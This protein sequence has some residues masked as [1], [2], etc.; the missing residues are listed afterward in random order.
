MNS[1]EILDRKCTALF[2]NTGS[3]DELETIRNELNAM[4]TTTALP[5]LCAL[6]E[7][8]HQV[9]APYFCA[10]MMLLV[11]EK[12][13]KE[14]KLSEKETLN[15]WLYRI[16]L[17]DYARFPKYVV[18]IFVECMARMTKLNGKRDVIRLSWSEIAVN[19]LIRSGE[20]TKCVHG[21]Q[22]LEILI[23]EIN[24]RRPMYPECLHKTVLEHFRDHHLLTFFRLALNLLEDGIVPSVERACALSALFHVI[25]SYDFSDSGMGEQGEED[26]GPT[27][28]PLA[29]RETIFTSNVLN[30]LWTLY[31]QRPE[32]I[33][34]ESLIGF[35]TVRRSFFPTEEQRK[36]WISTNVEKLHGIMNPQQ[37]LENT[38]TLFTL[39]RMHSRL[40]SIYSLA[41]LSSVPLFEPWI[42]SYAKIT[43]DALKKWDITF[44]AW[45]TLMSFWA[46]LSNVRPL[47]A[48]S[49]V[50]SSSVLTR[51]LV[52]VCQT[53]V[54]AC[55]NLGETASPSSKTHENLLQNPERVLVLLETLSHLIR[56]HYF[57]LGGFL[58]DHFT[59]LCT[60]LRAVSSF[61]TQGVT[62]RKLT[63][64]VYIISLVVR[65]AVTR[66]AMRNGEDVID[67]NLMSCV[68]RFIYHNRTREISTAFEN[69]E[70]SM[71]HAL[72]SF[73]L[74][75]LEEDN[76]STR[77]ALRRLIV[78]LED[79]R[80]VYSDTT[81]I[82]E[83]IV[84]KIIYNLQHCSASPSIIT[85][86]LTLLSDLAK[87]S[88]LG[89]RLL[90]LQAIKQLLKAHQEG[91][92]S[93]SFLDNQTQ[94]KHRIKY[95]QALSTILFREGYTE[96]LFRILL[97]PVD[98]IFHQITDSTRA[99]SSNFVSVVTN[100]L[101]DLLGISRACSSRKTYNSFFDWIYE[102]HRQSL[103]SLVPSCSNELE[104][105][106]VFLKTISDIVRLEPQR[107]TFEP[108][109]PK[110]LLLF[111]WIAE[112]LQNMARQFITAWP[113]VQSLDQVFLLNKQCS[114][115]LIALQ[116]CFSGNF[117]NLGV[118]EVYHDDI[119]DKTI[120]AAFQ[121]L[122]C[123]LTG[124][125]FQH[126]KLCEAYFLFLGSLCGMQ[127]SL[128]CKLRTAR[129]VNF[130]QSIEAA[131]RRDDVHCVVR[132]NA[133]ISLS[134][135]A[136]YICHQ[137][138]CHTDEVHRMSEHFQADPGLLTRLL[139]IIF[140]F[141]LFEKNCDLGRLAHTLLPLVLLCPS[142]FEKLRDSHSNY[143]TICEPAL[144]T[145]F[146]E[147]I[148]I[149]IESTLEP[150]NR[151]RFVKNLTTFRY[152]VKKSR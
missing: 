7:F 70:A 123:C 131:L 148:M 124:D 1:L 5:Q 64:I 14:L 100:G 55:M 136:N 21:L 2:T 12:K 9:H 43:C 139:E 71:I 113:L 92:T 23:R 122:D 20:E 119:F 36:T 137:V 128:V 15:K 91:S 18:R 8:S 146:F 61:E 120:E 22:V 142:D 94:S 110:G 35:V 76:I 114:L 138:L 52:D 109:S 72:Q 16:C 37:G 106:R 86:S 82:L 117:C 133:S 46:K 103:L 68:F 108:H 48:D 112:L 41:E 63:W 51:G 95:Y 93:F 50:G 31:N 147:K 67:A 141:V 115:V 26:V 102:N 39:F 17:R 129:F 149:G 30:K 90:E 75:Y 80:A 101:R 84:E 99:S 32:P 11:L 88:R 143:E 45:G 144:F 54:H 66:G 150:K 145:R 74:A 65:S 44:E 24:Q 96:D 89:V 33:I 3:K 132:K 81:H 28:L 140:F 53:L 29:W 73:R 79:C 98:A 85:Q 116:Q 78:A 58:Q 57:I 118:F 104:L 69:L 4:A 19:E 151:E 49:M 130:M 62:Y 10:Q 135:I 97:S 13:W 111:K 6:S 60:D 77:R 107:I 59:R 40:K 56:T 121:M 125:L 27:M 134:H 83:M 87:E 38:E 105:G 127:V 47:P 152:T 42:Q 126:K 34:L 25:L